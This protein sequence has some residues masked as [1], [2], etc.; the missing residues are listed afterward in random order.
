VRNCRRGS[1]GWIVGLLLA[2][3]CTREGGT[4]S[5]SQGAPEAPPAGQVSGTRES[6][7]V[8]IGFATTPDPPR[9]G[10]NAIE[11][12]IRQPDGAPLTDAAV[13]AVFSMP[14]MP[15]MNMPAMRSDATLSHVGNGTYRGV[16]HL[17]MV[18][19][20]NVVVTVTRAGDRVA[21]KKFSIVAK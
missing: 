21:T 5:G 11:M 20:W 12:T 7:S 2:V 18:G 6:G 4:P 14:A 3:G 16:G 9:P 13:I 15:S 17:S 19:T 8:S 1:L 10:D